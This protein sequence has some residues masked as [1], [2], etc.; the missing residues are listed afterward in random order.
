MSTRLASAIGYLVAVIIGTA[1]LSLVCLHYSRQASVSADAGSLDAHAAC[2]DA[3][4]ALEN[5]SP[6]KARVILEAAELSHPDY[7]P[8]HFFLGYLAEQDSDLET[9]QARYRRYLELKP[10]DTDVQQ[11]LAAIKASMANQAD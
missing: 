5:G 2:R 1:P 4:I 10:E 6:E 8:I 9:A 7:A 11:Q 3:K